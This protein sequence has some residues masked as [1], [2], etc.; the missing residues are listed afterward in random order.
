MYNI[1]FLVI[2]RIRGPSRIFGGVLRWRN[3]VM[4][5][6]SYR[7][8]GWRISFIFPRALLKGIHSY[9]RYVPPFI[10]PLGIFPRENRR[11]GR[12]F[13]LL[14][15]L[16]L[17]LL[18]SSRL[19]TQRT[20]LLLIEILYYFIFL[21][22]SWNKFVSIYIIFCREFYLKFFFNIF[23]S[24]LLNIFSINFVLYALHNT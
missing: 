12:L 11:R 9:H 2:G 15:P 5:G 20:N 1:Y 22:K 23:V 14:W 24:I 3:S 7:S 16:C 18:L 8:T 13:M 4:V 6:T 10:A 19:W 17:I 21:F